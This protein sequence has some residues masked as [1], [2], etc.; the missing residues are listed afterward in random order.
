MQI[1]YNPVEDDDEPVGAATAGPKEVLA[2][3]HDL[4][5]A[6]LYPWIEGPLPFPSAFQRIWD[7][8]QIGEQEATERCSN[9]ILDSVNGENDECI[10]LYFV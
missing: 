10:S 4:D 6:D 7:V 3:F 8:R 9:A 5:I 2:A 1:F